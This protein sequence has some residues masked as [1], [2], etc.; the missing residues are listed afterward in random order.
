MQRDVSG[1]CGKISVLV[2]A[3]AALTSFAALVTGD[4][5]QL[6]CF[7]LQQFIAR[8]FC[9]ASDQF[10]DLTLDYFLVKL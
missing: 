9:A 2:T 6:V 7:F 3:A 1:G 4:L 5:C 8:F 10:F